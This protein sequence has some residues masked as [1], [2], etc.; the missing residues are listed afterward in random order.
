MKF[1]YAYKALIFEYYKQSISWEIFQACFKENP[2]AF[3]DKTAVAM[4]RMLQLKK[5][6]FEPIKSHFDSE[7]LAGTYNGIFTCAIKFDFQ[8]KFADYAYVAPSFD[9]NGNRI[10]HTKKGIL[11]RI[12]ITAFHEGQHSWILIVVD[13]LN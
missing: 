9:L 8:I 5:Q 12:A 1:V 6:E 3:T 7:I 13:S 10:R 4:Y 2:A 11:H